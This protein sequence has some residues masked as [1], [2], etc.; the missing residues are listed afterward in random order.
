MGELD[1]LGSSIALGPPGLDGLAL[2]IADDGND[3][4]HAEHHANNDTGDL[5]V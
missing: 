2:P 5:A 4:R 3:E 1:P